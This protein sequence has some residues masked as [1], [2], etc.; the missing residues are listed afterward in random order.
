[1]FSAASFYATSG[2]DELI[3]NCRSVLEPIDMKII[4][5]DRVRRP[6]GDR[7]REACPQKGDGRLGCMPLAPR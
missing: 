7:D 4:Q 6:F 1:M 3:A 5:Y 2:P